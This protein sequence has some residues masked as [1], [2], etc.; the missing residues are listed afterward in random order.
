[1]ATVKIILL[2]ISASANWVQAKDQGSHLIRFEAGVSALPQN[3]KTQST[4][5]D[6]RRI[7]GNSKDQPQWKFV[8]V[9]YLPSHCS[10][11][12]C[13]DGILLKERIETVARNLVSE[14]Q[15]ENRISWKGSLQLPPNEIEV[16]MSENPT[17]LVNDGCHSRLRIKDPSLPATLAGES[18]FLSVSWG[19]SVAVGKDTML[20]IISQQ[21]Y[22]VIL[23]YMN[24]RSVDLSNGQVLALESVGLPATLKVDQSKKI[25]R[26]GPIL[27][28]WDG[29]AQTGV[30]DG[31]KCTLRITKR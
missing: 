30:P 27:Q 21:D 12:R 22:P 19:S 9:G 28:N 1:M 2:L 29:Q 13:P 7:I 16:R 15:N 18:E 26:L 20:K 25:G 23:Q 31:K 11:L 10:D 6:L 24:G 14:N 4:L 8:L 3:S 5:I 17:L